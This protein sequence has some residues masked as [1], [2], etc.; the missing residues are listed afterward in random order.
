MGEE[1]ECG[2]ARKGRVVGDPVSVIVLVIGV[3]GQWCSQ[4]QLLAIGHHEGKSLQVVS[5]APGLLQ[6]G[7]LLP[8]RR[9]GE[10]GLSVWGEGWGEAGGQEVRGSQKKVN[11][12]STCV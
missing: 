6:G 7:A 1:G 5:R 2:T 4:G 9:R 11:P 3:A 12:L 10:S 8:G